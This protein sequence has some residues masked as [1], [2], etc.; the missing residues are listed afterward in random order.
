MSSPSLYPYDAVFLRCNPVKNLPET[1][2]TVGYHLIVVLILSA[3][4]AKK[5]LLYLTFL[6]DLPI[7]L[8]RTT[9]KEY[10]RQYRELDDET[11]QKIAA[12]QRGRR[13]S[14]AHRQ[15]ISQAME[16]YWQTVPHRPNADEN[17]DVQP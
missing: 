1:E 15:H 17:N 9:M 6:L 10:K 16:K 13:K 8:K 14:E 11:K 4:R 12:S 3:F 7:Y 5:S 2:G